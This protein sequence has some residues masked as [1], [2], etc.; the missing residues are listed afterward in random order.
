MA[1]GTEAARDYGGGVTA[2]VVVTCLIAAS[3]G[4]IFGYDI[5]VTGIVAASLFSSYILCESEL[6]N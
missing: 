6:I 4:L 1:A 5:G 3:C 2:S